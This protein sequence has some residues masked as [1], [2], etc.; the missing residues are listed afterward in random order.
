M[1]KKTD[2]P[3]EKTNRDCISISNCNFD[4]HALEKDNCEVIIALAK[5]LEANANAIKTVAK[6]FKP[7][8]GNVGP[9]INIE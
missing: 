2:T 5:A 8:P 7:G 3:S 1:F 4:L 6:S 9:A